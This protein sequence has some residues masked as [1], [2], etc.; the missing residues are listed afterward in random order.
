[1]PI[2]LTRIKN[3]EAHAIILAKNFKDIM[4]KALNLYIKY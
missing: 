2:K 1:M 4:Y 3:I